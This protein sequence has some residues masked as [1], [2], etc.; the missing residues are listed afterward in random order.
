MAYSWT[1][2]TARKLV[3]KINQY[4]YR[5]FVL[6]V[7]KKKNNH[8]YQT[9]GYMSLLQAIT[10][11]RNDQTRTKNVFCLYMIH[12]WFM[13]D[14]VKSYDYIWLK[15][16]VPWCLHFYVIQHIKQCFKTKTKMNYYVYFYE[17]I[18]KFLFY[19]KDA[20]VLILNIFE[21]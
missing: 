12:W 7:I 9:P 18:Y 16:V 5:I 8:V 21:L 3:G 17:F 15:N 20:V 6:A 1:W 2:R 19:G 4:F 10:M 14:S 11:C 13:S